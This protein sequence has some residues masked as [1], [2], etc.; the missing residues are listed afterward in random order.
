MRPS[1]IGRPEYPQLQAN[2]GRTESRKPTMAGL[3]RKSLA[4]TGLLHLGQHMTERGLAID[5]LG[6]V[7]SP[8]LKGL[9]ELWGFLR[10]LL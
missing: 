6:L 5:S 10:L 8:F 3:D 4:S 1:F 7:V 9:A 2:V